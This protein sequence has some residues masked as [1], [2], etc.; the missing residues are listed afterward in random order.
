MSLALAAHL[1]GLSA[2]A[3]GGFDQDRAYTELKIN[4]KEYTI[5]AAIAI[6]KPTKEALKTETKTDRKPL[7]EISVKDII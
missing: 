2:H 1:Q 6:G 3:M 7:S 5:M 4:K